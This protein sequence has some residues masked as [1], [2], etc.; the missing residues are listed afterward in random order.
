MMEGAANQ[1]TDKL[2]A[3]AAHITEETTVD[4]LETVDWDHNKSSF[5]KNLEF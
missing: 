1:L 2:E 5:E 4:N 3:R